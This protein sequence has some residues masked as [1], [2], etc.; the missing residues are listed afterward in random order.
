MTSAIST[1]TEIS[2]PAADVFA[3][4]TDPSRFAE[5]QQ[6]V[7]AG[8]MEGPEPHTVGDR[9]VM[10]RRIGLATR[11]TT[12]RLVRLEP[13]SVWGVRGLDGPVRAAVDVTVEELAGSRTR[14]T[15]AVDFEGHGVGRALVPLVV[16]PQARK[17]MPRNLAAAKQQLEAGR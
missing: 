3:Y 1:S 13:P 8:R 5:W 7:V 6:G 12:S 4:I 14:L 9:C 16:R 17:E 11:T 10:T 2:R 15:I